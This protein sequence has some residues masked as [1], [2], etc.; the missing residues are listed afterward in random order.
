MPR[1]IYA[2]QKGFC[3]NTGRTH[4]RKGQ[5]SWNKGTK[6]ICKANSGSFHKGQKIRLGAK[7]SPQIK[8]KM[9]LAKLGKYIGE[10][11]PQFKGRTKS[12]QGYVLIYLPNHP[13][14]DAGKYVKRSRLVMEKRLKRYLDPKEIVHHINGIKEDD[15]IKNL[16]LFH[17]RR[18]HVKYHHSIGQ[19]NKKLH[20][21]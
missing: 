11:H 13:F 20:P 19:R 10:K 2:H 4:F 9:S 5:K 3:T 16:K 7:L 6:G 21:Q 14:C 18:A 8:Q 17:N 12:T 15:R 1:G